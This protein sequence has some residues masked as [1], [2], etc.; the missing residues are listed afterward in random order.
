[1]KTIVATAASVL[2]LTSNVSSTST[3]AKNGPGLLLKAA[4]LMAALT[5]FLP[6]EQA[7]AA[8]SGP[9]SMEVLVGGRDSREYYGR[10]TTYVE[11]R[12]GQEYAIRLS[13]HTGERVA[14]AL[15]VDGL[16]S[17]DAKHTSAQAARKW[18]LGP[19]ETIVV[20]GWQTSSNTARHFYFTNESGSYGSYMGDTRN[21]G[22]IS[23]AFF[24]E[25]RPEPPV[26]VT[27]QPYTRNYEESE[28]YDRQRGAA[29]AAPAAPEAATGGA[30]SA[31]KAA[32]SA[33]AQGMM[34]EMAPKDELAATG[35]GRET[36]HDVYTTTFR[37]ESSPSG[38]VTV[39]YEYRNKLIE[40]GILPRPY[41][42]DPV[43][44]RENSS[45]FTDYGYAP[46]PYRGR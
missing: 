41:V 12:R 31:R 23:A 43:I 19:Y 21:L 9:Y 17:I 44:R 34:R 40:L 7:Q 14:V 38:V 4:A 30:S 26:Y 27:P 3:R 15:A 13:N 5:C 6:G 28:R 11:A 46:D 2:D 24:R 37:A 32:P 45:G 16:N 10:G 36:R 35:I 42:P 8:S 1:M 18:I 25:L 33:S 22:N 39:R 29:D 20:D